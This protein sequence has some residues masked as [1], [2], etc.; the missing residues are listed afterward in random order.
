MMSWSVTKLIA[1]VIARSS[2]SS[3]KC[4]SGDPNL[5]EVGW[6]GN[7]HQ[8]INQLQRRMLFP[9]YKLIP[10]SVGATPLLRQ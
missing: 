2:S 9:V 4:V 3:K 6:G 10:W 8:P 5:N 7:E 1:S